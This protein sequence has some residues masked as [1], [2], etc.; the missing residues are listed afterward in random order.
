M[1]VSFMLWFINDFC[2]PQVKDRSCPILQ[3]K[4][5]HSV[6][7]IRIPMIHPC[8][9]LAKF[10][11]AHFHSMCPGSRINSGRDTVRMKVFFRIGSYRQSV[12]VFLQVET[13][14]SRA[15]Y[16]PQGVHKDVYT[17]GTEI[18]GNECFIQLFSTFLVFQFSALEKSKSS[19][20]LFRADTSLPTAR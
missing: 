19:I 6:R 12:T 14:E 10:H 2:Q 15:P 4:P 3:N 16:S 13:D 5:G 9:Y 1:P 18:K 11:A 7:V 17:V 20:I 8:D